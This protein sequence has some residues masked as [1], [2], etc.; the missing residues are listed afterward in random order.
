[1]AVSI[2]LRLFE[3]DRH[4][5]GPRETM[6]QNGKSFNWAARI[7]SNKMIDDAAVLYAFCRAVDD[8]AD[9]DPE[10]VARRKLSRI[11][12]ELTAGSS[13]D[14]VVQS[15]LDLAQRTAIDPRIPMWF[16]NTVSADIGPVRM[17]SWDELIRY[18]YGVASTVGLL[19]CAVMGVRNSAAY[20]FAVDLGIGMQL[21]NIARDVVEDAHRNRRYL[22]LELLNADFDVSRIQAGDS[23]AKALITR[24]RQCVLDCAVKYYRSA[25]LGMRFIPLRARLAVVTASRLYEAI[26]GRVLRQSTK[27]GQRAYVGV[28]DKIRLTMC[29]FGSALFLPSYWHVG[30]YP[31]HDAQ[32]H[33][34]LVGR[35]GV[36]GGL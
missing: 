28:P 8:I 11:R 17:N 16:I 3:H 33:R 12:T 35:P 18:A 36:N 10:E 22:P 26:G 34:A 21:T 1:M 25:D 13:H 15:F 5:R 31:V 14:P 9:N 20:P 2:P 19:M 27:W 30:R 29:A 7:F 24:A 4:R 23:D 32:L 6:A